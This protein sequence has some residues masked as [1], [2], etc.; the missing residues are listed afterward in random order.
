[1]VAKECNSLLVAA[2]DACSRKRMAILPYTD[3]YEVV[4]RLKPDPSG[5]EK[6]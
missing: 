1:M 3:G 5:G 2:D 4:R 6:P